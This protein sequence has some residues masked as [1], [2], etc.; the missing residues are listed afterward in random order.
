MIFHAPRAQR[1]CFG[2]CSF[3]FA[4]AVFRVELEGSR[5]R[6]GVVKV[7]GGRGGGGRGLRLHQVWD[8][9]RLTS[10]HPAILKPLGNLGLEDFAFLPSVH[11]AQV[12]LPHAR[13][14]PRPSDLPYQ[15]CTCGTPDGNL[16]PSRPKSVMVMQSG[17]QTRRLF[18]FTANGHVPPPLPR[19]SSQSVSPTSTLK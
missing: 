7:L 3:L 15:P 10:L 5:C 12:L 13:S 1:A 11:G 4:R 2:G 18:P 14:G 8:D 16:R 17:P 19:K 6:G 9:V